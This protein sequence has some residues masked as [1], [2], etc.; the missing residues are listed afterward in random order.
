MARRLARRVGVLGVALVVAIWPANAGGQPKDTDLA[1]QFRRLEPRVLPKEGQPSRRP[2][3]MVGRTIRTQLQAVNERES[4][5]WH[6]LRTRA[7]WEKLP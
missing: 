3:G 4:R 5:A 6:A 1:E 2:A 7:D